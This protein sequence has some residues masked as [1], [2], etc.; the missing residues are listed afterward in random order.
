[1]TTPDERRRNLIWGREALEEQ[2]TD[3]TLPQDWRDMS[4]D[5]LEHYPSLATLR[6]C[7]D[8]GLNPLQIKYAQVLANTRDLF[9]R[10][11]TSLAI[12]EERRYSLLVILRHFY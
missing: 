12:T 6:Y 8:D 4:A 5:L 3:A 1:M 7:T 11:R 2:S 9:Q 10:M